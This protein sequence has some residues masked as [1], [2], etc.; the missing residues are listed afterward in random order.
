M[1]SV[2]DTDRG[3][4]KS[5]TECKHDCNIHI[6]TTGFSWAGIESVAALLYTCPAYHKYRLS[7]AEFG[8][9]GGL[10]EIFKNGHVTDA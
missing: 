1:E 7:Q 5:Q 10:R 4:L 6:R 2:T 3:G 8:Q 9:I